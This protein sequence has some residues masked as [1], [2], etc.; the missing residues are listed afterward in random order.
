M[1]NRPIALLWL[2]TEVAE[3]VR[4]LVAGLVG[5]FLFLL[6]AGFS[7]AAVLNVANYGGTP[8]DSTDDTAG[9]RAAIARPLRAT[10]F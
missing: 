3:A 8:N 5:A 6:V 1:T 9:I 7:Q 10:R 4:L 2:L